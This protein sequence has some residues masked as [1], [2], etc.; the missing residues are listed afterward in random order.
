MLTVSKRCHSVACLGLGGSPHFSE[1][2]SYASGRRAARGAGEGTTPEAR[3]SQQC[4]GWSE[5]RRNRTPKAAASE[6]ISVFWN[7]RKS[8]WVLKT[9]W[10][11]KA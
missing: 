10:R 2:G 6:S 3:N 8:T 1:H 7:H 5:P 4:G 11:W 9:F